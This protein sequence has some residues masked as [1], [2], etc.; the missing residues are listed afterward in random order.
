[1][2]KLTSKKEE[3]DLWLLHIAKITRK[4][5]KN[6]WNFNRSKKELASL[7]KNGKVM[8]IRK[9]KTKN[10]HF[11]FF[12]LT[13]AL[14]PSSVLLSSSTKRNQTLTI[15]LIIPTTQTGNMRGVVLS[16][17]TKSPKIKIPHG[18]LI[19]GLLTQCHMTL[20]IL[21]LKLPPKKLISKPQMLTFRLL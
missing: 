3:Q 6:K 17:K 10:P 19:V 7:L 14:L 12:S 4:V 8:V 15:P 11:L 18:F 2:N 20:Q 1:M 5:T 16:P 21:K 9:M 13:S